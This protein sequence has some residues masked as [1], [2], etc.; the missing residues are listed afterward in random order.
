MKIT[1][2][3]S[4]LAALAHPRRLEVFRLLV[5][6]GP[7]GLAAMEISRRLKVAPATLSFHLK[8]LAHQGLITP[9]PEG[10]FIYYA[11]NFPAVD[12]LLGFLTDN[13]CS[14]AACEIRP[15]RNES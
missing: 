11:A 13:C 14:G 4:L 15:P 8:E 1:K 12:S 3:A 5:Q 2:A 10:R 6:A 9:R 7:D